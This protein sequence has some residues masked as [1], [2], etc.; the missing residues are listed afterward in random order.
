MHLN[1]LAEATPAEIAFLDGARALYYE[2]IPML[3]AA[4][5][6]KLIQGGGAN[7]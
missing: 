4:G 1:A 7:G 3:I 5:I 6:A 2:E